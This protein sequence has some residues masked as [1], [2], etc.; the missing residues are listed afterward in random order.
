METKYIKIDADKDYENLKCAAEILKQGGLVAF[1][2]ETVYGLGAN[3][4]N[5]DAVSKIFEAKG[6]PNDNPLILHVHNLSCV[7]ELVS[8]VTETA[9]I[10]MEKFWP[11]PMTLV[12]KKSQIVP[13]SVSAGLDTVAI[14]F[15]EHKIAQK[16]IEFAN[17]PIAAPSANTSGR[18]SP[19]LASH[20]FE[21]MNG[22]IEA[23]IDGGKCDIGVESTVIDVTENVPVILRPGKVTFEEIKE[24]IPTVEYDK[25]LI[26]QS[27]AVKP[28][29][30]GMKY[31]HYAPKGELYILTGD[32]INIEKY[33]KENLTKKTGILTFDEYKM[34]VSHEYSL[35]S[36]DDLDSASKNLFE[37]LRKFDDEKLEKMYGFMPCDKGVGFAVCNRLLKAAGGKIIEV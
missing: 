10:L 24:L 9:E 8:E 7:D 33:I 30:P 15:P 19:T 16:L 37:I 25:H 11:G 3:G 5:S 17:L 4:L 23:I 14:R 13:D 22:K 26:E 35:G 27:E 18:P 29:S 28:R 21:D 32:P 31:K 20:V 34:G 12:F 2:T 1:P 36:K 6:R